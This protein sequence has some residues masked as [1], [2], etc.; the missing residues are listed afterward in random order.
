MGRV[1]V[2]R[3]WAPAYVGLGS[4]LGDPTAELSLA[5][6]AISRLPDTRLEAVSSFFRNPPMGRL[7]QPDFVNAAAGLLT[8]LTARELLTKLKQIELDHGRERVAGDRWGPRIIDLDLLVF[9]SLRASCDDL[10]LPHSG[11]ADR[12]FVLFPLLE[13][14][15]GLDVPGLGPVSHLAR[16]LDA[17]TLTRVA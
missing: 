9:G 2:S 16:R 6:S 14:A 7:D 10:T 3:A 11:I 8:R 5:C 1:V 12:N 17:G 4:N 13:I 15:P